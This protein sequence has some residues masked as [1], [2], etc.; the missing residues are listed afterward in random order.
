VAK[1]P[2]KK[3]LPR[4]S[5]SKSAVPF[6]L[7]SLFLLHGCAVAV[8]GLGAGAGAAA[9]FNGKLTKTYESD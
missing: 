8:I 9:Y 5:A 7:I 1:I 4:L 3:S 6:I 2:N